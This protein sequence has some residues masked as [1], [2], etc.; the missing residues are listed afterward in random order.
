M[1]DS[2]APQALDHD[3]LPLPTDSAGVTGG[4]MTVDDD[5]GQANC[6]IDPCYIPSDTPSNTTADT[7]L[8]RALTRFLHPPSPPPPPTHPALPLSPLSAT[9]HDMT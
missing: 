2:D 9:L 7:F 1:P 5:D 4:R 3:N 8:L 6:L